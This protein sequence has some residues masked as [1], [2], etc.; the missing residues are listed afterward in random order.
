MFDYSLTKSE[1]TLVKS[2]FVLESRQSPLSSV[3]DSHPFLPVTPSLLVS[4][5]EE[6]L[7]EMLWLQCNSQTSMSW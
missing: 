4:P 3:L 1:K 5:I 7:F 2:A 6:G